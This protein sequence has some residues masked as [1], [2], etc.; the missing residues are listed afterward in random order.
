MNDIE[1]AKSLLKEGVS[2]AFV[3]GDRSFSRTERGV[4]PLL[5]L[6]DAGV[7]LEGFSAADRVAGRAAA[8]LYVLLGVGEVY[9][10][11]MSRGAAAVFRA[12]GIAYGYRVL[13][14]NIVN[15]KGTGS[16][17]MELA[18]ENAKTPEEALSAIRATLAAMRAAG[19]KG[20]RRV[21]KT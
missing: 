5:A 20:A 10:D 16:C 13:T 15:R 3:C 8:Y 18:T 2:C 7:P 17:P 14:E 12:H 1:R 6:L 4:S 9:A 19:E 21:Q 11:V